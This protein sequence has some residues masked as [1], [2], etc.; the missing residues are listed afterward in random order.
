M[1][2]NAYH[3]KQSTHDAKFWQSYYE[4]IMEDSNVRLKRRVNYP[5][6]TASFLYW[7]E[8]GRR[9][10]T[11][12]QVCREIR[13]E[14]LPIYIANME[15]RVHHLE[16]DTYLQV[17]VIPPGTNSEHAIETSSIDYDPRTTSGKY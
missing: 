1:N 17:C 11:L 4:F 2:L 6:R 9:S 10:F 8:G 3:D 13:T 14:F 16:T 12:T 15:F 5:T 7:D